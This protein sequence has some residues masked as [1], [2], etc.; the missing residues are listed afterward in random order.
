MND[1]TITNIR[2]EDLKKFPNHFD[3]Q[4]VN[5]Y[6]V[7]EDSNEDDY[8]LEINKSYRSDFFCLIIVR[9]GMVKYTVNDTQYAILKGGILFCNNTD[10]FSINEVTADYEAKYMYFTEEL[11][12]EAKMNFKSI[13]ILQELKGL[14]NYPILKEHG[15]LEK[16]SFYVNQLE[17]LNRAD[18]KNVYAGDMIMHYVSLMMYEMELFINKSQV[19]RTP[20]TREEEIVTSFFIL[21]GENYKANHNVQ[22]YA[23]KLFITRKYLSKVT[24]KL[25][26]RTPREVISYALM[27]EAKVLL[28]NSNL[29]ITDIV[30]E[31]N[32]TDQAIFSKFFKKHAGVSPTQ[33][34]QRAFDN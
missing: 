10:T 6:F 17:A 28:R 30:N 13:H 12:V 2:Y 7:V 32:F 20:T 4:Y 26:F 34:R 11:F 29:S 19:S 16:F 25:L 24:N 8:P 5:A 14:F 18:K 15:L 27:I 1:L 22:F 3:V 23:D 31:L 33:F 21:V 9:N